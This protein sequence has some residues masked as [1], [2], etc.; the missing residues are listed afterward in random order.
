MSGPATPPRYKREMRPSR[1]ARSVRI[2]CP[3][4]DRRACE[5]WKIGL[6]GRP[7]FG[8]ASFQHEIGRVDANDPPPRD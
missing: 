4:H 7:A 1:T 3:A 6:A 8:E 5:H 2:G